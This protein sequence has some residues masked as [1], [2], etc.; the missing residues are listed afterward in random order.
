[1]AYSPDRIDWK[2]TPRLTSTWV[3]AADFGSARLRGQQ[4]EW[5]ISTGGAGENACEGVGG[6]ASCFRR[7]PLENR[8]LTR[9]DRTIL[10]SALAFAY[11]ITDK[12]GDSRRFLH[13]L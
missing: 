6:A 3:C 11:S 10:R 2:V 5:R 8:A 7:Q 13:F 9:P 4:T 12:Y 1:M